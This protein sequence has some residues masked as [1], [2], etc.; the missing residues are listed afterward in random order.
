MVL[1]QQ[2]QC[3]L[4][5]TYKNAALPITTCNRPMQMER[6]VTTNFDTT[7]SEKDCDPV[8]LFNAVYSDSIMLIQK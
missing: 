3:K 1:R 2:V 6:V 8:D 4:G 5:S 7:V